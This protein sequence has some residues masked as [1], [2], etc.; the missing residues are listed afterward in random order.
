MSATCKDCRKRAV[1]GGKPGGE[2]AYT[3]R[4]SCILK[5]APRTSRTKIP[6]GAAKYNAAYTK[7]LDDFFESTLKDFRKM[8]KRHE[9]I[10]PK[11]KE[12]GVPVS[13]PPPLTDQNIANIVMQDAGKQADLSVKER[14]RKA[15]DAYNTNNNIVPPVKM[16]LFLEGMCIS[17]I[18]LVYSRILEA[19]FP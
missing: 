16:T 1:C 11:I 17:A 8:A 3:L 5:S 7:R 18:L 4:E 19:T 15:C 10:F 13:L 12:K 2:E 14:M 9:S 6:R